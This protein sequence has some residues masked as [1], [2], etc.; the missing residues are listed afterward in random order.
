AEGLQRCLY[1]LFLHG[2]VRLRRQACKQLGGLFAVGSHLRID[3][4]RIID[5]VEIHA[6][7]LRCRDIFR[8]H[9]FERGRVSWGSV[10]GGIRT[11]AFVLDDEPAQYRRPPAF[12]VAHLALTWTGL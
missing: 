8:E 11:T 6:T 2:L 1:D 5:S 9:A 12:L 7:G 4:S 10:G 3:A